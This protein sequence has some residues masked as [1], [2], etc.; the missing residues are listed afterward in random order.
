MT[1]VI[2]DDNSYQRDILYQGF[3]KTELVPIVLAS[4]FIRLENVEYKV[5]SVLMFDMDEYILEVMG[6]LLED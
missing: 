3:I 5:L 2:R 6:V 4:K 1:I